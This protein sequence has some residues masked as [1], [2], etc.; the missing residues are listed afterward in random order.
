MSNARCRFILTLGVNPILLGIP[1]TLGP[2]LIMLVMFAKI[3]VICVASAADAVGN[4]VT[5]RAR[6]PWVGVTNCP[7]IKLIATSLM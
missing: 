5:G 4:P 3:L 6:L 2:L 1:A 7:L